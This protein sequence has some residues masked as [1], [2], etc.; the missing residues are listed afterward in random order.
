MA[1]PEMLNLNSKSTRAASSP[2]AQRVHAK[3]RPLLGLCGCTGIET[4]TPL[5]R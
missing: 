1:L 4:W 5:G 3:T 2:A